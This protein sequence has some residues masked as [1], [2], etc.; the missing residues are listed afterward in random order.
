MFVHF[1]G[2]V[3]VGGGWPSIGKLPDLSNSFAPFE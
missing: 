2:E 3:V 1:N